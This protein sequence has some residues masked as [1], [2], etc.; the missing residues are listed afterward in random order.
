[1][2]D[3]KLKL[4]AYPGEDLHELKLEDGNHKVDPSAIAAG[5]DQQ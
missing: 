3:P 2:W 4:E 1:M 5:R